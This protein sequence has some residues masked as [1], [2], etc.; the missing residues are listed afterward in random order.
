MHRQRAMCVDVAPFPQVDLT[1]AEREELAGAIATL[2]R[3]RERAQD[4]DG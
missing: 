4:F 3:A 1:D 2:S